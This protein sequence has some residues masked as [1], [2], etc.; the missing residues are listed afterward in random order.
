MDSTNLPKDIPK[1]PKRLEDTIA[2]WAEMIE[3]GRKYNCLSLG[4]GA[5]GYPPAPFLKELMIEA[6]EENVANN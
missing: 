6:I 2:I 5:P 1:Q 3:L 4:E